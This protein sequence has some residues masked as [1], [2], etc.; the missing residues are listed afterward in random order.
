ME[1]RIFII[2]IVFFVVLLIIK[3]V[4]SKRNKENQNALRQSK[5]LTD[6]EF[7]D[8]D[9]IV[10]VEYVRE[11]DIKQV[12]QQFCDNY[13]E[14]RFLALPMLA[15]ISDHKFAITFP[16]DIDFEIFCFFVNYCYYPKNIKYKPVIKA[17]TTTSPNDEWMTAQI[18]NKKVMLFI[19][20]DDKDYNNVY[21][22]TSDNIGYKL[23]FAVGEERQLLDY[24][25]MVF[26]EPS[27]DVK[28][29]SGCETQKFQ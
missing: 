26:E 9:K 24:P 2:I 3:T 27:V 7:T 12:I 25:K 16:Y 10:V 22:T 17:W 29:L 8:N 15:K 19:P 14:D 21:L 5:P 23:G 11:K 18:T 13:N 4:I 28:A 1:I 20:P 6:V